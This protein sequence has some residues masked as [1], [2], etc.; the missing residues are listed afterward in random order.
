MIII[1]KNKMIEEDKILKAEHIRDTIEFY[2][3]TNVY[4]LIIEKIDSNNLYQQDVAKDAI[5]YADNQNLKTLLFIT[6][7]VRFDSYIEKII[8][9]DLEDSDKD[10]NS[11]ILSSLFNYEVK[12][13]DK[14]TISLNVGFPLSK[15]INEKRYIF[16]DKKIEGLFG[17]VYN[18][19][20]YAVI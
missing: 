17:S 2:Y 11:E 7:P 19:C 5:N 9:V 6:L 3:S 14:G 13:W 12:F 15:N 8:K 20:F 4:R 1:K 18:H 10:L 16:D